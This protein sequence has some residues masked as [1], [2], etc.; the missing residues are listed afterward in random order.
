MQLKQAARLFLAASE[1]RA[2]FKHKT[3]YRPSGHTYCPV[4]DGGFLCRFCLLCFEHCGQ[5]VSC[6]LPIVFAGLKYTF[7]VARCIDLW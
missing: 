5:L 6:V 2:T 3:I 7:Y 4:R 1:G